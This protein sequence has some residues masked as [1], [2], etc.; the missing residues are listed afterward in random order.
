MFNR[1]K[2][3]TVLLISM[4]AAGA[5]LAEAKIAV[6]DVQ[7][8]ILNSDVAQ[9][10]LKALRE[11]KE[12]KGNLQELEKLQ[13]EH[14]DIVKKLKKDSAVMNE[15]QLQAQ[16][17]KISEKRADIEHVGRKLKAAEQK[18][19]QEVVQEL[20]PKLNTVVTEMIKEDGIGMIIDAKAVL[21][22]TNDYNI[23]AKVTDK[24]NQAR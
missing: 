1:F 20:A 22:V 5:A 24:L 9:E 2:A 11:E 7:A 10:R 23:T 13:K 3:L 8:A 18:L 4:C 19:V 14:N 17:Q 21:H 15:E 12:F 6:I 16:T